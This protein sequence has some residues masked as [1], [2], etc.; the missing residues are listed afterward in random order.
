MGI[1]WNELSLHQKSMIEGMPVEP[2]QVQPKILRRPRLEREEQR[3]FAN[4]LLLNAL[5]HCWHA[6]HKRSTATTGVFDFWVGK[7]GASAWIEFKSAA[8]HLSEE[9]AH[10]RL[11]L[12]GEG[13][14]W[15]VVR[16]AAE[17][18]EIIKSWG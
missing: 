11:Q 16:S 14:K 8:G 3:I 17:A 2:V 5:P 7:D 13:I 1:K 12:Q 18:I 6:T 10:F 15:H 9:Q 4:W